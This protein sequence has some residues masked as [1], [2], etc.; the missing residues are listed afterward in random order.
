MLSKN[1]VI[2][3]FDK[4]FND[5]NRLYYLLITK[6]NLDEELKAIHL[7]LVLESFD[8]YLI[9]II[10]ILNHNIDNSF[11]D[12]YKYYSNEELEQYR[13]QLEYIIDRLK[14]YA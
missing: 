10:N 4:K 8:D 5:I 3:L 2:K 11:K 6:R 9:E 7:K 13:E 14:R 12:I 1:K